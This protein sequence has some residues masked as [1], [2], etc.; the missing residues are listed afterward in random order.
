MN[1]TVALDV[2]PEA[3]VGV[4]LASAGYPGPIEKGRKIEGVSEAGRLPGVEV[5]HS[6]TARQGD[7]LV[8]AGGR[9]LVVTATGPG[10]SEASARAYE[11]AD[12]IRFE[13]RTL[14]RD[15]AAGIRATRT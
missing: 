13:G 2:R 5:F 10:L 8:T 4:V 7:A 12:R 11:A 14:R 9:V 6:G 15:I 3:C 1:T